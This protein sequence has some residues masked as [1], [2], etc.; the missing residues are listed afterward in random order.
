MVE[1]GKAFPRLAGLAIQSLEFHLRDEASPQRPSLSYEPV[2]KTS[3]ADSR[4]R[5]VEDRGSG[6]L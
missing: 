3:G 2:I 6:P 5:A 4:D 1:A